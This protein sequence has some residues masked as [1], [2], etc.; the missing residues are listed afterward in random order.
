MSDLNEKIQDLESRYHLI[1]IL[2]ESIIEMFHWLVLIV[3]CIFLQVKTHNYRLDMILA[4]DRD[5][6]Q[7]TK[8]INLKNIQNHLDQVLKK[9]PLQLCKYS[10]VSSVLYIPIFGRQSYIFL[11]LEDSPIYSYISEVTVLYFRCWSYILR[12]TFHLTPWYSDTNK[13]WYVL[14]IFPLYLLQT[15]SV[16]GIPS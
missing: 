7:Q 2:S 3:I 11:Y 16:E 12:N 13:Q 9:I 5:V 4:D 14:A 15:V 6:K 8:Q 1:S 10:R